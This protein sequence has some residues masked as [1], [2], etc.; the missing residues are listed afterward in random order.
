MNE[1]LGRWVQRKDQPYAGLWF[2]FHENGEFTAEYEAMAIT[3]SG[4]YSISEN[5]IDMDQTVHALG[6][7]GKFA[8]R[9]AV[10][11]NVLQLSLAAGAGQP[12]PAD[13]SKA[14]IYIKAEKGT[15]QG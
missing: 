10:D 2:E 1:I 6:V 14:R 9:F 4:T 11:G 3:S 15:V 7:T 8:G 12:R 5:E 13:L